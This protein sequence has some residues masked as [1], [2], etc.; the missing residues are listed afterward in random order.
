MK[1]V[2]VDS[3]ILLDVFLQR[4]PFYSPASE[5]LSLADLKLINAISTPLV[6]SNLFYI[7]RKY[8][9]KNIAMKTL[10]SIENFVDVISVN[11]K[12]VSLALDSKFTDFEDALQYFSCVEA[13]SDYIVTRNN[14]DY[15][16]SRIPVISAHQF[17]TLYKSKYLLTG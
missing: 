9:S 3:D 6:F 16:H 14:K 5:L 7:L 10:R 8:T 11:G 17:M 1:K 2:Y 13:K 15:Q 12:S 4:D